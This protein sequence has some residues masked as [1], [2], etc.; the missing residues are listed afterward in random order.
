MKLGSQG[1][2]TDVAAGE[3]ELPARSGDQGRAV[4]GTAM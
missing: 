2:Y 3:L 1:R 4:Q